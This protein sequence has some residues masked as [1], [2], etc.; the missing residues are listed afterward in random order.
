[1][2]TWIIAYISA[3]ILAYFFKWTTYQVW[4]YT[5]LLAIYML[6]DSIKGKLE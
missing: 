3:S 5:A 4:I 2:I 6:L 1:M